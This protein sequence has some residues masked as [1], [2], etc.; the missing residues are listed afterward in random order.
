VT[1]SERKFRSSKAEAAKKFSKWAA[2]GPD[3]AAE[4]AKIDEKQREIW[5]NL[6]RFLIDNGG[7]ITSIRHSSPIRFEVAPNSTVPEQLRDLGFDPIYRCSEERIGPP[8]S[9]RHGWR[10]NFNGGYSFH[11][12]DVYELRLPK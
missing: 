6:N 9:T 2:Q 8:V 12:R 5:E 10:S 1:Y 11:T 4:K 7:A 3:A